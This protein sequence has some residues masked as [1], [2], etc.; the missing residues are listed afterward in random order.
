MA[1]IVNTNQLRNDAKTALTNKS[2][3]GIERLAFINNEA[4]ADYIDNAVDDTILIKKNLKTVNEAVQNVKEVLKNINYALNIKEK[5]PTE[6][7]TPPNS[8]EVPT[9]PEAADRITTDDIDNSVRESLG[10]HIP[11]SIRESTDRARR[12]D[13]NKEPGFIKNILNKIT[14][15]KRADEGGDTKTINRFWNNAEAKRALSDTG[16]YRGHDKVSAS[17][18]LVN[19]IVAGISNSP[20]FNPTTKF[21]MMLKA[22]LSP[23]GLALLYFIG[24]LFKKF[25]WDPY[26]SPFISWVKTTA[27]PMLITVK[28]YIKDFGKW[29]NQFLP[30]WNEVSGVFDNFKKIWQ[31]PS[32]TIFNKLAGLLQ[33]TDVMLAPITNLIKMTMAK[34]LSW[35]GSLADKIP[36][37]GDTAISLLQ[38]SSNM[39]DTMIETKGGNKKKAKDELLNS[40]IG[41]KYKKELTPINADEYIKINEKIKR[42]EAL[43]DSERAQAK[44]GPQ[45]TQDTYENYLQAQLK[46]DSYIDP[47]TGRY[48]KRNNAITMEEASQNARMQ[49]N[50]KM[51]SPDQVI[52][53]ISSKKLNTQSEADQYVKDIIAKQESLLQ[54]GDSQTEVLKALVKMLQEQGKKTDAVQQDLNK[55]AI[56]AF[57]KKQNTIVMQNTV[58]KN[59]KTQRSIQNVNYGYG[60][61]SY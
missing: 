9:T 26:L 13:N 58:E 53:E 11:R 43:T 27:M 17:G 42:G 45:E 1:K 36:G 39:L 56:D 47:N 44:Q 59:V 22:L 51:Q 2:N 40:E 8:P 50:K 46:K 3:K 10:R 31:D 41:Q 23:P 24:K 12:E 32:A 14:K 19:S 21:G 16:S 54:N 52:K 37:L 35:M 29:F 30:T 6:P 55:F 61:Q 48:V 25:I 15:I 20:L 49:W 33:I 5:K 7:L 57:H 4:L 60:A 18:A 28:E 34:F 38:A